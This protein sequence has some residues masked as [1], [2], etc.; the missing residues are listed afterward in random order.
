MHRARDCCLTLSG[1]L[2]SLSLLIGI[3]VASWISIL[4]QHCFERYFRLEVPLWKCQ[5]SPSD[6]IQQSAFTDPRYC[7]KIYAAKNTPRQSTI[8][9]TGVSAAMPYYPIICF[10]RLSKNF[11]P[12]GTFNLDSSFPHDWDLPSGPLM[13]FPPYLIRPRTW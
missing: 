4:V 13:P 1:D 7:P 10:A 8:S 2:Q 3:A 12:S 11:L 9:C 6:R 5:L